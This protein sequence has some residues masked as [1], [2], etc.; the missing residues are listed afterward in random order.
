MSTQPVPGAVKFVNATT[1]LQ[2]AAPQVQFAVNGDLATGVLAP[3]AEQTLQ[4]QVDPA[5]G[6]TGASQYSPAGNALFTLSVTRAAHGGDTVVTLQGITT[7]H[8]QT[9]VKPASGLAQV[10]PACT[11]VNAASYRAFNP[12]TKQYDINSAPRVVFGY[13]PEVNGKQ[14][15]FSGSLGPGQTALLPSPAGTPPGTA[16][17]PISAAVTWTANG[18]D[19]HTWLYLKDESS[20]SSMRTPAGNLTLSL[21]KT[22]AGTVIQLQGT[23]VFNA[24]PSAAAASTTFVLQNNAQQWMYNQQDGTY[25]HSADSPVVQFAVNGA[26]VARLGPG[27]AAT[28]AGAGPQELS[29][30]VTYTDPDTGAQAQRAFL[31]QL[32]TLPSASHSLLKH[33]E[34]AFLSLDV[35]PHAEPAYANPAT[36]AFGTR[37]SVH[38]QGLMSAAALPTPLQGAQ[39]FSIFNEFPQDVRVVLSQTE[40]VAP[41]T[42]DPAAARAFAIGPGQ[43]R[44]LAVF[45]DTTFQFTADGLPG[46]AFGSA[47]NGPSASTAI[48]GPASPAGVALTVGTLDYVN[49]PPLQSIVLRSSPS[50]QAAYKKT[51]PK[52]A[53]SA[54]AVVPTGSTLP[55]WAIVLICLLAVGAAGGAAYGIWWGVTRG[56]HKPRSAR[57]PTSNLTPIPE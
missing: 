56:K 20:T 13:G 31:K 48:K 11:A 10:A 33:G 45:P 19:A 22:P 46:V 47:V 52:P 57:A 29:A 38:G 40:P 7:A 2:S 25:A 6:A 35:V 8:P 43:S 54:L 36:G 21:A 53:A 15:Q 26:E 16:P 50:Q 17:L 44:H 39:P 55:V 49:Q 18:A 41:S 32:L 4:V 28:Y 37:V 14:S 12:S 23:G 30:T 9:A 42:L 27:Q 1:A 3:G 34:D 5:H 51:L 24:G